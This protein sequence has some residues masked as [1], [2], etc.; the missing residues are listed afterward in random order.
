MP[1]SNTQTRLKELREAKHMTQDELSNATGIH[2]VTIARYETTNR[3]MTIYN[4]KLLASA[5]DCTI[6]DLFVQRAGD[7]NDTQRNPAL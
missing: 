3:G 4:A 2:R 7:Q 6:D 1:H 5:L